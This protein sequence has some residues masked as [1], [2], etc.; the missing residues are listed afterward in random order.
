[1]L[2]AITF[3]I[4]LGAIVAAVSAGVP[5][6]APIAFGSALFALYARLT[7][8]PFGEILRMMKSGVRKGI[9][10]FIV[11]SMVGMVTASWRASGTVAYFVYWGTRLLEPRLFLLCAFLLASGMAYVAGTSFGTIGTRGVMLLVLARTGGVDPVVT[12]GAVIAGSYVGDRGS[13]ASS[14]AI[15]VSRLTETDLM[16]NVRRMLR[17]GFVPFLLCCAFYAA[18]SPAHPL[19]ANAAADF[20]AIREHYVLSPLCVLP[21]L[22]ILALPPLG[23]DIRLTMGVSLLLASLLAVFLQGENALSV[24]R[25]LFTGYVPSYGGQLADLLRG[26]GLSSMLQAAFVVLF[27]STYDGIFRGTDVLRVPENLIRRM[28]ARIGLFP[29]TVVTSLAASMVACNQTLA[30][31]MTQE[32][33]DGPAADAGASKEDRAMAL[34]NS[35]ILIA[36]LVPWNIA[37]SAGLAVLEIGPGAIPYAAF[38]YLV[39]VCALVRHALAA[40]KCRG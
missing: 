28:A 39:P 31:M 13:P 3:L 24:L 5:I 15:L 19:S 18:L 30:V 36:P 2:T 37:V 8:H 4:F 35:V 11:F 40:K 20:S 25:A 16:G 12:A 29:A 10:V 33:M 6:V 21:A 7:G 34:E 38:L 26:G 22:V 32:L 9:L 23:C 27:A 1:M 14:S 17:T